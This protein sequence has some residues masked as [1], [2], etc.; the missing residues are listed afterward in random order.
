M[1]ESSCTLHKHHTRSMHHLILMVGLSSDGSW[2]RDRYELVTTGRQEKFSGANIGSSGEI[3]RI[4]CQ[5]VSYVHQSTAKWLAG[6]APE[7][8]QS[9]E[10]IGEMDWGGGEVPL[11]DQWDSSLVRRTV[12]SPDSMLAYPS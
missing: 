4:A 7:N 2:P 12:P 8:R 5:E 11:G 6:K 10:R 9:E 1:K 3:C